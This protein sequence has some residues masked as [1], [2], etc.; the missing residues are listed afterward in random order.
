MTE[1]EAAALLRETFRHLGAQE[2]S[3]GREIVD[4]FEAGMDVATLAD[5]YANTEHQIEELIRAALTL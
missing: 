2:R 4:E 3:T 5:I 1:T